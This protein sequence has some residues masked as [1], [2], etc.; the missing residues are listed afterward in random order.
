MSVRRPFCPSVGPSARPLVRP[1]LF[2]LPSLLRK[3][4]LFVAVLA[5]DSFARITSTVIQDQSISPTTLS[6]VTK[7]HPSLPTF[8]PP[9]HLCR[10]HA[11]YK[12]P[13][14]SVG[15][16]VGRS[17]GP[18]V[19]H[20]LLFLNFWAF[21]GLESMYLSM[22]CPNHYCPCPTARDRSSRVY[23]LVF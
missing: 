22:P 13:C 18:S 6:L 21:Y 20:T 4:R 19:R 11:T 12:S 5:S 16:S 8:K 23:G 14:Q 3:E 7:H 15:R 9:P 1:I 17:V 2:C 10:G